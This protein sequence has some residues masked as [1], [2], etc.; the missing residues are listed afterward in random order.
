MIFLW[1]LVFI[2][3]DSH[4]NKEFLLV[5]VG[6]LKL[7]LLVKGRLSSPSNPFDLE[8]TWLSKLGSLSLT[9][10][11]ECV[12]NDQGPGPFNATDP[13]ALWAPSLL[14]PP[15][16]WPGNSNKFPGP[17]SICP[18]CGSLHTGFYY[19]LLTPW[20]GGLLRLHFWDPVCLWDS[21]LPS[22]HLSPVSGNTHLSSFS[23]CGKLQMEPTLRPHCL[24]EE[25]R[26]KF[27]LSGWRYIWAEMS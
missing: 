20:I 26:D 1:L 25:D 22:L 19:L 27:Y 6:V 9:Q 16:T 13:S 24:G 7:Q 3:I 21:K 11:V 4:K 12:E 5:S 8:I 10:A 18:F 14:T 15:A 17:Q 2:L 23:H